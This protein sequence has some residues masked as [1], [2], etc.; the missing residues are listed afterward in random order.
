MNNPNP[1]CWDKWS[2]V[3]LENK[4]LNL[5]P[6]KNFKAHGACRVGSEGKISDLEW[7]GRLPSKM[8]VRQELI[9]V[10]KE[11]IVKSLLVNIYH[12]CLR[13]FWL[14]QTTDVK[15]CLVRSMSNSLSLMLLVDALLCL[16]ATLHMLMPSKS[17]EWVVLNMFIF[18]NRSQRQWLVGCQ[19]LMFN[20]KSG[21]K[22]DLCIFQNFP[23]H[24]G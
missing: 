11:T 12:F 19:G 23:K 1:F 24:Q 3:P 13:P 6:K 10:M 22:N 21:K 14:L 4:E 17:C 8:V 20:E 2:F 9:G 5:D 18:G 16:Y 15:P 7:L